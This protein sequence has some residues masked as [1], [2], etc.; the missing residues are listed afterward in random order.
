MGNNNSKTTEDD[1]KAKYPLSNIEPVTSTKSFT[2]DTKQKPKKKKRFGINLKFRRKPPVTHVSFKPLNEDRSSLIFP[3]GISLSGNT[4]HLRD[5]TN[6]S[7]EKISLK[8][9]P[10]DQSDDLESQTQTSE[11]K[12]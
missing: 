11:E 12:R 9:H 1:K 2:E 7:T 6:R 3:E 4:K 5:K 10:I 8:T